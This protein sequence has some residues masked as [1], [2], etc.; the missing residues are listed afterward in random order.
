[1]GS[2][3]QTAP[4][5]NNT[6]T[7]QVDGAHSGPWFTHFHQARLHGEMTVAW[8]GPHEAERDPRLSG[9]GSDDPSQS[10]SRF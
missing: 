4:S 3:W 5:Q 2:C 9:L 10:L 1:M 6:G 7:A 8:R